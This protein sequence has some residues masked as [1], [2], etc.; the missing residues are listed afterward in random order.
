M[1]STGDTYCCECVGDC[2]FEVTDCNGGGTSLVDDSYGYLPSVG[3]FVAWSDG[4][5]TY[6]GEVT[7]ENQSGSAAGSVTYSGYTD[8][9]DCNANEGL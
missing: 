2:L 4:G 8:C 6:C 3:D 1:S 9:A 5:S 7:D